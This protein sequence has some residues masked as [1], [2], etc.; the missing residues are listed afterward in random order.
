MW[1]KIKQW[2]KLLDLNH[3]GRA[4]AEDLELANALAEKKIK[5]A[6]DMINEAYETVTP[7]I[8]DAVTQVKK[9]VK[10]KAAPKAKSKKK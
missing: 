5:E 4:T 7:Q 8:T 2:L 1:N 10:A 9:K 6:S 3:D